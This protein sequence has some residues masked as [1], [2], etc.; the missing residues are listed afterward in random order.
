MIVAS[1]VANLTTRIYFRWNLLLKK[2]ETRTRLPG[3][4]I[5]D[6]GAATIAVFGM[7]RVGTGVYDNL[8]KRYD[9]QIIGLDFDEERILYHV[10]EG[11]KV[12]YGD[13]ADYD[14]WQRGM[15]DPRQLNLAFLSM[16]HTANIAAAQSISEFTHV[17]T[18][19]ATV[20]YNDEI[21]PLKK[22]GVDLVF[23]IY[24][25]AGTGFSDHV[26][27]MVTKER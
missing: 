8:R 6:I 7:G 5:V 15:T 11:R 27:K 13:P 2:F 14:F 25:E 9:K 1:P 19:A 26:C 12:I 20:R 4:D 16:S 23:D 21:A 10:K 24:D 22:A 3:D 17:S 18:L